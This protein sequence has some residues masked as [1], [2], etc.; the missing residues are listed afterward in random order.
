MPFYFLVL[1]NKFYIIYSIKL[2]HIL[3]SFQTENY[4]LI[5]DFED[6]LAK[7]I[8]FYNETRPHNTLKYNTPQKA[9]LDYWLSNLG[10]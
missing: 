3:S 7:Y 1:I 4:N 9:E 6:S 2:Y 10:S 5:K 8:Q